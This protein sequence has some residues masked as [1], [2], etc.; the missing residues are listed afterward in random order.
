V[1][2]IT[3]ESPNTLL[4]MD[5]I[6]PFTESTLSP[7]EYGQL[8]WPQVYTDASNQSGPQFKYILIVIDYF[9]RFVWAF[10]CITADSEEVIRCLRWLFSVF[11]SPVAI[12][13][14]KGTHFNSYRT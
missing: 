9:S 13:S 11:S 10:P 12:Y 2:P 1:S 5:F 7:S 4:R 3:V 14:D 8:Q 6:G